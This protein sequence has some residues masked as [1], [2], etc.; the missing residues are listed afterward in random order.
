M[1]S[2]ILL[3]VA[4]LSFTA[5]LN[6][7]SSKQITGYAI[8]APQKGQT[9][10]KEVRLVDITTGE[11]LQAIYKSND[12]IEILNARTGKPVKNIESTPVVQGRK[13]V[14]L[15][16]ELDKKDLEKKIAQTVQGNIQAYTIDANNKLQTVT[17]QGNGHVETITKNVLFYFLITCFLF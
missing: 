3:V 7:Q 6:A 9:G 1:K 16:M 11:E 10:W 8:T 15:D 13:V 5:I 4:T 2:K 14:N 17:A 12:Q